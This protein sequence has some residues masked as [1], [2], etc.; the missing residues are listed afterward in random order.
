MKETTFGALSLGDTFTVRITYN[1]EA[2]DHLFVRVGQLYSNPSNNLLYAGHIAT[3]DIWKFH[4]DCPIIDGVIH[5]NNK[6][7]AENVTVKGE[8]L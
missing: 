7:N 2:T 1:G 6:Y 4:R 5:C 8:V 3:G